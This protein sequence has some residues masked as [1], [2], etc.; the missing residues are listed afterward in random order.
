MNVTG[1]SRKKQKT[2]T[3]F[4]GSY[5]IFFL[6]IW[7]LHLCQLA[8]FVTTTCTFW[9]VTLKIT[10][11]K[12]FFE[13][14]HYVNPKGKF[15]LSALEQRQGPRFEVSSEGLSPEIDILVRSPI[16]LLIEMV[17]S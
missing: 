10:K 12:K 5:S 6:L 16:Q 15:I 8:P 11:K 2:K 9:W 7:T 14:L 4:H 3:I 1:R 13:K 17:V